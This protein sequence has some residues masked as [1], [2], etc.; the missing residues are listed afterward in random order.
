MAKLN[1]SIRASS[2]SPLTLRLPD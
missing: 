2:V 1:M